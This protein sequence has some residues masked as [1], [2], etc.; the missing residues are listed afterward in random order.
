MLQLF[1]MSLITRR[2]II[3]SMNELSD[4]SGTLSST[5]DR[6]SALEAQIREAENRLQ[7][8]RAQCVGAGNTANTQPVHLD[9]G[10]GQPWQP[11]T[12]LG[13]GRGAPVSPQVAAAPGGLVG[14]WPVATPMWQPQPAARPYHPLPPGQQ[15]SAGDSRSDT[16]DV[17]TE[18]L[19]SLSSPASLPSQPAEGPWNKMEAPCPASDSQKSANIGIGRGSSIRVL[20]AQAGLDWI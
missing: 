16:R 2:K 20:C 17:L 1:H 4:Q 7:H 6:L 14:S 13:I 10:S 3:Q 15:S 18:S 19:P 12:S 5:I 9:L 11:A 8:L